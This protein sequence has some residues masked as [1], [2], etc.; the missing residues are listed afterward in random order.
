MTTGLEYTPGWYAADD[1]L[2][3]LANIVGKNGKLITSHIRN[4]DD[5]AVEASLRELLRQG[6]CCP[7]HVSH[8]KVVY[9]KGSARAEEI[10]Q[11]LSEARAAGVTVTADVYPYTASYTGIG[12]VFPDW[13][14]P[15]HDYAQVVATRRTELA[16]F[17][18]NKIGPTQRTR[19]HTH[20][21][22]PLRW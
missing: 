10:L 5:E 13:A 19:G 15:P 4:E 7:V 21:H 9:G 14:K 11:L 16:G 12:I 1:E 6:Q 8:L 3:Y 22:R 18:R 17:L 2:M 20:R